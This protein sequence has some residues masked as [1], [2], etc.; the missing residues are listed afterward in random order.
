M[1]A[2]LAVQLLLA[3]TV[4][5]RAITIAS[6][7]FETSIPTTAG[8]VTPESGVGTATALH[9][10]V[11]AIYSN[12]TGNGSSESWSADRWTIGDYWLFEVSTAGIQ[13]IMVSYDQTRS[14]NGPA[15]F[16]FQYSLNGVDF[17]DFAMGYSVLENL[18]AN[19]GTWST[20]TFRS[21]YHFDRDLS[22]VLSVD[23]QSSVFF[24][25]RAASSPTGS[26]TS[27]RQAGTGRLDNFTVTGTAIPDTGST[28]VLFGIPLLGLYPLR[29]FALRTA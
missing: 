5:V 28:A 27:A 7:T 18:S 16:D 29:R 2:K 3:A 10:D 9:A 14:A 21:S 4:P 26:T 1:K 24:K 11:N 8:P 12:P 23:N 25:I 20:T 15:S 19:G 17:F 22:A 13:D 6:W